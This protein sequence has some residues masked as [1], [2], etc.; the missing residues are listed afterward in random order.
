MRNRNLDVN[1]IMEKLAEISNAA[2]NF[3]YDIDD[4]YFAIESAQFMEN[5]AK[6]PKK[7]RGKK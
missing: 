3:L 6:K 1:K 7:A 4:I 5:I 2:S